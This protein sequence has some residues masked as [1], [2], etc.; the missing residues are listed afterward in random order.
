[1]TNCEKEQTLKNYFSQNKRILIAFSGGVDSSL[2][3]AFAADA[4]AD[5][6]VEP[7]AVTLKTELVSDEEI[8]N[9]VLAAKEIGI[10][11]IIIEKPVLTIPEIRFNRSNRCYICKKEM[12]QTLLKF[13]EEN[14]YETVIEGTNYSDIDIKTNDR[15]Q[16]TQNKLRPGF[17]ALLE[18]NEIQNRRGENL[19]KIETPLADL[20]IRKNEIRDM[21]RRR[22]LISADK[23]SMSCLATRFSYDETLT[24]EMI[25]TIGIAEN[26][27]REIGLSQIRIRCHAD[28][29]QR[30]IARIEIEKNEINLISKNGNGEKIESLI[31]FLKQNGFSYVTVDL[32]GFR[33]GSMDENGS[34][35]E[36][37]EQ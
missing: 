28:S 30:R 8:E 25:Q 21:A 20:K 1:M 16:M 32:E 9:A 10:K 15:P 23:P 18:L 7:L 34:E 4:S 11:H 19:P 5:S 36:R 24:A 17:S 27:L 33:S 13:A 31:S 35:E 12:F 29:K 22:K 37:G 26:G 6:S 2:L 14:D 3:A